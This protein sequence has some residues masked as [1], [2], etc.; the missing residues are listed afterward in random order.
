MYTA[1]QT[2][3][4]KRSDISHHDAQAYNYDR[5]HPHVL[6]EDV[7]L[8]RHSSGPNLGEVAPDFVLKDTDGRE[9]RLEKLRGK[10][11]VF[12]IGSGTCPLTQGNLPGLQALYDEFGD[13]ATWLMLYVR[14]AHPGENMPAHQTYEQKR[15]QAEYFKEMTGTQWP[16]LVDDL[17]GSVH[18]S[19]KLLPNSTY[20]IDAD[21]KVSFIGEISHAPTLRDA[22]DHLFQQNMRGVVPEGDDKSLHMLGPTAYGWDAIKRGG[23]VSMRDVATRMPP[24]AMNLWMGNKMKPMLAPLAARSQRLAPEQKMGIAIAAAS[25]GMLVAALLRARKEK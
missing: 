4:A 24:L 3:Q 6:G 19:F 1:N 22:L 2:P 14:E 23:H 21:G 13:R 9:W 11:V 8:L 20:L 17:D 18:K 15:S 10:P 7:K 12:I 16:V 5:F 25:F